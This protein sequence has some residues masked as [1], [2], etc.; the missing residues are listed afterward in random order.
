MRTKT[1]HQ[2]WLA[3]SC[4]ALTSPLIAQSAGDEDVVYVTA[5][6]IA[7]PAEQATSSITLL[8]SDMLEA[9]GASFAADAL[10]AVPGLA[11][12]R[13]GAPGALTQ[14]RARGSEANHVLVLID[15]VEASNPFTGEADFS[16]YV[17]DDLA[18]IEVARGEQSALW[19][20]DAIGGVIRLNSARPGGGFSAGARIETGS[21]GT[22]RMS[23]RAG[24]AAEGHW[25]SASIS[26][27]QGDGIDVS[28]LNAERDG[29]DNV[30]TAVSGGLTISPELRLEASVRRIESRSEHDSDTDFD[31]R[32]DNADLGTEGD[33][34]LARAALLARHDW[35][36]LRLSHE[37]A[38]QLTDDTSQTFSAG[39]RTARSFGQRLQAHYEITGHWETGPVQHR[40]TGLLE[41]DQDRLKSHAG[42]GAGSNQSRQLSTDALALDYG[43]SRGR[44]D[45]TLSARRDVHSLFDDSTTWRA[46]VGWDVEPVDGRLR[47]NFG[48]AVKNPGVFELFGFFPAFFVGN[49]A[50]TP[51]RSRGWEVAWDQTL[52]DGSALVSVSYFRSELEDE[53]YTDFSVFPATA[54]NAPTRSTRRGVEV[55]GSWDIDQDW[56]L[57]GSLTALESEEN[58]V[59]EIRRPE[60]LASL[61][62]AWVP[63][64]GPFSAAL[65]LDH[66]GDQTDTDFGTFQPVTLDAYTL[67]GGQLGWDVRPGIEIYARGDNLLDE[68]YQ[69]VFGYHTP[70]RG[71]YVGLRFDHG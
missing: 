61:T 20:A 60:R 56:S 13:S 11:M 38:L 41:H 37:T 47:G 44:W 8:D 9:R 64:E 32:L 34:V 27:Y 7:L 31:G 3:T 29:Y 69:D 51:E 17:F 36:G 42:P 28:G 59:A 57:F 53:I 12:S 71:L 55:F 52:L 14:I 68:E 15:G 4:L 45:L 2:L 39:N 70:G 1:W 58:G 24:T 6:R 25:L 21:F 30:T 67:V 26:D 66:T 16:H 10:R 35:R 46:G 54:L 19:G 5:A 50:L 23:L 43:L 62:L 22:Q 63:A 49:P 18:S 33:T 48:A 40:L 65:T